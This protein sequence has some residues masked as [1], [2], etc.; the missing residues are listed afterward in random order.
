MEQAAA[1]VPVAVAVSEPVKTAGEVT[2]T[3]W[4]AELTDLSALVKAAADGNGLALRLLA[5][6]QA[7]ANK[8]ATANRD[9]VP[10]PGV[11]FFSPKQMAFR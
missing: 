1:V 6:D 2:S 7:A 5:F 10:V 3:V 11:R 4:R 9:A 8:A